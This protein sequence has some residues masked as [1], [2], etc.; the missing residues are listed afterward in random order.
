MPFVVRVCLLLLFLSGC[1][2]TATPR[3]FLDND[4]AATI[5]V[6][7]S[8]W[9]FAA[10]DPGSAFVRRGFL[11]L[12]AFDVNRAGT[13]QHYFA[14]MQSSFDAPLPDQ[15]SSMQTL[16][17]QANGHKLVF[18][19]T[20]Q[21]PR[22]LGV[23]QPLDQPLALESRWWYFPA[24]KEDIAAVAQ[25]RSPHVMLAIN[26]ARFAYLEFRSGSKELTEFSATLK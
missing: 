2:T 20:A 16:E 4:T 18:Q 14:V 9:V 17:L 11:N 13:H 5:T 3:Q 7:A 1:A 25:L 21:S 24:T 26:D 10:D 19:S 23:A 15:K 6:V 8:P 22:Q 12:Y